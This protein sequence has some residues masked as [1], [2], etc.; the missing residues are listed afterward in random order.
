MRSNTVWELIVGKFIA[1][2]TILAANCHARDQQVHSDIY[3]QGYYRYTI[4]LVS[5]KTR[6]FKSSNRRLRSIV[7]VHFCRVNRS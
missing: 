1:R 6:R 4:V 3:E 2:D 7:I 5:R